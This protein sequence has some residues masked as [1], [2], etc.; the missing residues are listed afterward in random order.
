MRTLL[1]IAALIVLILIA[2]VASG[3]LSLDRRSDGKL[4]VETG[5]VT[6]GTTTTNVQVPRISIQ[7]PGNGEGAEAVNSQ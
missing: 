6:V 1:L 4:T 2:L 7:N 5:E 3:Y